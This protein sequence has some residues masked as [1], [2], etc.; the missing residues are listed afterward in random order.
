MK[1]RMQGLICGLLIGGLTVGGAVGAKQLSEMAELYYNNIKIYIDGGEMIPK[2]ANG[3]VTEPFTV[4]GTTYLPVRAIA[5]AFGKEVE[6]DGATQSIYIGKKD[7][8]KP[9]NYLDKI[10]YNDYKERWRQ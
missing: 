4:N 9:D 2:D 10:Q 8:T 6:W 7:Q 3:N 1:K 5:G